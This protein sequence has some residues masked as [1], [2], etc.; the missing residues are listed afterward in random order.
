MLNSLRQVGGFL[1]LMTLIT[2]VLYPAVVTGAAQLL[3]KHAAN[4]SLI[5]REGKVV[6]SALIGQ[7]FSGEGYFHPRPSSAGKDGYDAAASSG[8]NLGVATKSLNEAIAQRVA[9]LRHD[10]RPVP[11]DLAMASGSG[12]DP[13]LSP[14]AAAYQIDRVANARKLPRERVETLVKQHT[15]GRQLGFLGEPRVN[16][17][18]LNLAL[19]ALP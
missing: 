3:F 11:A 17:L 14:S 12:L 4:G 9:A 1:L 16:V 19:D 13:H 15:E 7:N 18:A 5:E 6:G 2:G 10:D 8:S